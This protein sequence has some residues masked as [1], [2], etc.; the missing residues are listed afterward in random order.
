MT[1][2]RRGTL[3]VMKVHYRHRLRNRTACGRLVT[4][5]RRTITGEPVTVLNDL[6]LSERHDPVTCLSCLKQLDDFPRINPEP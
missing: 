4:T 2:A 1:V 6:K 5:V 3:V